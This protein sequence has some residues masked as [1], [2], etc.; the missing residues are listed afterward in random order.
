MSP[1]CQPL[2]IIP[3][4]NPNKDA[5]NRQIYDID[6]VNNILHKSSTNKYNVFLVNYLLKAFICEPTKYTLLMS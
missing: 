6:L 4:L 1:V 2:F 5:S 3:I